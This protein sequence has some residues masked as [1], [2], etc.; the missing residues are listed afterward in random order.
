MLWWN[1][2]FPRGVGDSG[3][4]SFRILVAALSDEFIELSIRSFVFHLLLPLYE[5]S[6]VEV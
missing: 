2:P 4:E 1:V 5:P 6:R 3:R